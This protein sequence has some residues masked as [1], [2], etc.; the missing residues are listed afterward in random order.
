[1]LHICTTA[2]LRSLLTVEELA[3]IPRAVLGLGPAVS[4][5]DSAQAVETWLSGQLLRA[6]DRVAA[7]VNACSYNPFM[8]PGTFR[9]PPSQVHTA[10]VLAR[11]AVIS[12]IP[13]LSSTL[14]GSSRAAEYSTATA[15]L[16]RLAT[17]ELRVDAELAAG[18]DAML[19]ADGTRILG[20]KH[21]NFYV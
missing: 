6:C 16:Q 13:G 4:E 2:E 12:A 7:A 14:E 3:S 8:A 9:V 20:R 17:C 18:D 1:M 15:D 21:M 19:P 11:H 10:L 5:A